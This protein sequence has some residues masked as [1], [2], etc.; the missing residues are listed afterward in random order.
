VR[1]AAETVV[2]AVNANLGTLLRCELMNDEGIRCTNAV[3][4]TTLA[5][6]PT[7]FLEFIGN[8]REAAEGDWTAMLALALERGARSYKFAASG[9]ELDE[10]WDARRG[11]YLGA[12]RYRGILQGDPKRKEK[13]YVGDVCVPV[14]KLAQCVSE[15]EADFKAAGFPCVMC[16]HISDGNFHCLIP[17]APEE[18][19]RLM[20]L[21]DKVIGRAIAMGGAASGEHG[22]GVGKMK[23][24]CWE[25]GPFHIDMQR[26][27]KRAIDPRCIMNPG[28]IFTVEPSEEERAARH[29]GMGGARGSKL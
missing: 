9:E 18:E 17:F 16:A 19:D 5:E 7:L 27:I 11:C 15:T 20:A 23:H 3:F 4:A 24:I 29:R 10:L 1:A 13:V 26:R 6:A 22:V 25:H 28:K 8:T 21:Q 2:A 12:M 14:S